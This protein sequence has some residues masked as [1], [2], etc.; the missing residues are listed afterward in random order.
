MNFADSL[1]AT[2]NAYYFYAPVTDVIITDDIYN[3]NGITGN[4]IKT[5]STGTVI[6]GVVE[7]CILNGSSTYFSEAAG[8]F[9]KRNNVG[10][11][12]LGYIANPISG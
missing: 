4:F 7:D 12:P 1:I 9:T 3:A 10:Y 11:N 2:A 5:A 8:V 6:N